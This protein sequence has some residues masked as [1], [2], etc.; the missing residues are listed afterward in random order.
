MQKSLQRDDSNKFFMLYLFSIFAIFGHLYTFAPGGYYIINYGIVTLLCAG[1]MFGT[2]SWVMWQYPQM[3]AVWGIFFWSLLLILITPHNTVLTL[4]SSIAFFIYFPFVIATIQTID[5]VN[6]VEKSMMIIAISVIVFGVNSILAFDG[7]YFSGFDDLWNPNSISMIFCFLLPFVSVMVSCEKNPYKRYLYIVATLLAVC[8]IIMARSR[9]GF[10]VLMLIGIMYWFWTPRK[11][12]LGLLLFISFIIGSVIIGQ[13]YL[14]EM[15]TATD[16]NTTGLRIPMWVY[17]FEEIFLQNPLGIGINNTAR[18]FNERTGLG[19]GNHS[20]YFTFLTD[21]GII[22]LSLFL[23]IAWFNLRESLR[24]IRNSTGVL[25]AFAFA[26]FLSVIA[27]LVTG[28]MEAPNYGPY[29][30]ITT[31]FVVIA[32]KLK[33]K[34][35]EN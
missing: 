33:Y 34:H 19:G 6:K 12:W 3:K 26:C 11:F 21:L 31:A 18:F 29:F 2:K 10:V 27:F 13:D 4:R 7:T 35:V 8:I 23:V 22:G 32:T 25:N 15:S 9:T 5:S 28:I 16:L 20:M 1:I 17:S 30:W 14:Y 24:V